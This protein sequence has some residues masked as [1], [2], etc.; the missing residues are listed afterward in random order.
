MYVT[1]PLPTPHSHTHTTRSRSSTHTTHAVHVQHVH[2]HPRIRLYISH[3]HKYDTLIYK[4]PNDIPMHNDFMSVTYSQIFIRTVLRRTIWSLLRL[5]RYENFHK[6]ALP[7]GI[8]DFIYLP[9]CVYQVMQICASDMCASRD[10]RTSKA[11]GNLL[12]NHR[13]VAI[14]F[15]AVCFFGGCWPALVCTVPAIL[16][17]S[18][19]SAQY[20][21][22]TTNC[23]ML[24]FLR[25]KNYLCLQYTSTG[26][27]HQAKTTNMSRAAA[28]C[29]IYF[30]VH[31]SI[32]EQKKKKK[33]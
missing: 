21:H 29:V 1:V 26:G 7:A 19:V 31:T 5:S 32:I 10:D 12:D 4:D 30:P 24:E 23:V 15:T 6:S 17:A 2:V 27:I 25:Y 14:L 33:I 13:L 20:T 3:T 18:A 28:L 9:L 11:P 8:S 22:R 16:F